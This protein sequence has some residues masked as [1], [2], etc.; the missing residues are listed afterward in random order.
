MSILL[1]S[2]KINIYGNRDEK[3]SYH[4][5]LQVTCKLKDSIVLEG[6]N[7]VVTNQQTCTIT[8]SS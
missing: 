5:A 7:Y 6:K 1:L 4:H 2:T 8:M 3:G